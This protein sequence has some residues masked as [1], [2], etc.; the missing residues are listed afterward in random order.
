MQ[1][2]HEIR[3]LHPPLSCIGKM[4]LGLVFSDAT[5]PKPPLSVIFGNILGGMENFRRG[6]RDFAFNELKT[7]KQLVMTNCFNFLNRPFL[8][9]QEPLNH[10]RIVRLGVCSRFRAALTENICELESRPDS[11]LSRVARRKE[12]KHR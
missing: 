1:Q 10:A 2:S 12:R 5:W 8:P 4:Q 7:L 6:L 9:S 11:K 3:P